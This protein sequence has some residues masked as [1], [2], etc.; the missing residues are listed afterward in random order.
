[1]VDKV[2]KGLDRA[3]QFTWRV[4]RNHHQLTELGT[5][6]GFYDPVADKLIEPQLAGISISFTADGF[7]E[8]AYYRAVS[9]RT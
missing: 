4:K 8:E 5:K 7:Y 2:E 6:Q 9:N 3:G 1:M